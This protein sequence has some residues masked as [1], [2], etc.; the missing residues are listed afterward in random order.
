MRY[1][2]CRIFSH[3]LGFMQADRGFHTRAVE[4]SQCFVKLKGVSGYPEANLYVADRLVLVLG[5]ETCPDR[6]RLARRLQKCVASAYHPVGFP[7]SDSSLRPRSHYD[8]LALLPTS[9][10]PLEFGTMRFPVLPEGVPDSLE[11]SVM[12]VVT[13]LRS[14][15]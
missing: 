11:D 14:R 1:F 2:G 8:A 3:N 12:A 13:E 15:H 10:A 7:H 5:S 9:E 6:V 4:A